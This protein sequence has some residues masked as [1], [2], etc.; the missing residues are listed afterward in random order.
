M[1]PHAGQAGDRRDDY[2]QKVRAA[3]E[4]RG[5]RDFFIVARTDALAVEGLDGAIARVEAARAA[6]ADA[7]FVEAPASLEELRAI[8]RR[9][10]PPN[11]AN[12]IEGGRTPVLPKDRLRISASSSSCT[13]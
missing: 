1:R 4:A 11:V 6:G 7:S 12:L 2:V 5:G 3:V 9:A 8:G 10:P 13:R